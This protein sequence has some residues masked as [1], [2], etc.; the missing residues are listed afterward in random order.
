M[1]AAD[2]GHKA[3]EVVDPETC[4]PSGVLTRILM[5]AIRDRCAI[6][7]QGRITP[8]FS[9]SATSDRISPSSAAEPAIGEPRRRPAT[10]RQHRHPIP[11]PELILS[12][13]SADAVADALPAVPVRIVAPARLS[14][15]LVVLENGKTEFD[16]RAA[17]EA[18]KSNPPWRVDLLP[19]KRYVVQ[20]TTDRAH[21]PRPSS[22]TGRSWRRP[23]MSLFIQEAVPAT[24]LAMATEADS[25]ATG[26]LR[27]EVPHWATRIDVYDDQFVSIPTTGPV[28][29]SGES[30]RRFETEQTLEGGIYLVEAS[31]AG[32]TQRLEVPVTPGVVTTVESISLGRRSRS[33]RPLH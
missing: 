19:S 28:A 14:G 12:L 25:V 8:R 27:I 20:H 32:Q 9:Q 18:K 3:Y 21:R 1:L 17:S 30:P 15:E 11:P 29:Q 31:L 6:D 4:E 16:R 33:I 26:G 10:A 23:T 13:A 2:Y 22:S 7:E 5:K 24:D